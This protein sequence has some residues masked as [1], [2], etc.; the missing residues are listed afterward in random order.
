M[1]SQKDRVLAAKNY[2]N[3][4]ICGDKSPKC[5]TDTKQVIWVRY[6]WQLIAVMHCWHFIVHQKQTILQCPR[7]SD[8]ELDAF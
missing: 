4:I 8:Q 6:C 1:F 5:M 2:Q 3:Q 7:F